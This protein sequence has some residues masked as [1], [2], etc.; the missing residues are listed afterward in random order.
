[1]A[2]YQARRRDPLVDQKMQA[3]IERRGRELLGVMLVVMALLLGLMLASFS[4]SDPSW[5]AATDQP[6][7]NLLGSF[8]AAIAAPVYVIAGRGAWGIVLILAF[9]G[10]RMVTHRGEERA[11]SRAIFAPIAIAMMSATAATQEV[12][13]GWEQSFGYGGLFGD[14]FLGSILGIVP[15]SGT[16]SLAMTSLLLAGLTLAMTLFVLGFD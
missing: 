12:G 5:F 15:A 4:P 10:G 6:V 9:W 8:G 7:H 11:I 13:P 2:S 3:A 16:V 14:T 1:M